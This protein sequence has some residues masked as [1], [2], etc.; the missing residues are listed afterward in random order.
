MI[1]NSSYDP[2]AAAPRMKLGD[3]TRQVS[4]LIPVDFSAS[5]YN[6]LTYAL[7][8]ARACNASIHLVHVTDLG[9][10]VESSNPFVINRMLGAMERKAKNCVT[11]LRELIEDSGIEVSSHDAMIGNIDVMLHKKI[12]LLAPDLV[13]V[14]RE[15]FRKSTISRLIRHALSPTLIVPATI[16]PRIPAN[17]GL[18]SGQS[19]SPRRLLNSLKRITSSATAELTPDPAPER[20][21]RI[22]D[23][24]ISIDGP[25]IHH[26]PATAGMNTGTIAAFVEAN[27]IDL[28]CTM[29]VY[30]SALHR[31]MKWSRSADL[32]YRLDLPVMIMRPDPGPFRT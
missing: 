19:A 13:I 10:L 1:P 18:C 17:I 22:E 3:G 23:M 24:Q 7:K 20:T 9:E 26:H 12:E 6:S 21:R 8:L 14:G 11:A 32:V 16:E 28:L 25:R 4:F 15:N 31:V 2:V 29:P 30:A 27:S 5:A